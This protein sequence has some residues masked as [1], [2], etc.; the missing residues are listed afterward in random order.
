MA[1]VDGV[2]AVRL[3]ELVN[4]VCQIEVEWSYDIATLAGRLDDLKFDGTS[5]DITEQSHDRLTA[6]LVK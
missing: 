2:Q 1:D 4:N 6:M 5:C 3:R